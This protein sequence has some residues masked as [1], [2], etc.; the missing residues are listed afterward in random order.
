MLLA[1]YHYRSFNNELAFQVPRCLATGEG[2]P[3]L[4]DLDPIGR[5]ISG[6]CT[7]DLGQVERNW[8]LMV[9]SLVCCERDRG[10]GSY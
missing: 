10:A 9:H 4:L 8:S 5:P 7:G 1:I 3:N 6:S 2:R